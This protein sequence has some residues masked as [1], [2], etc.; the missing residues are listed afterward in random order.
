MK[1]WICDKEHDGMAD[2]KDG[3]VRHCVEC[4]AAI[5]EV[6]ADWE[7]KDR[8]EGEIDHL[9]PDE[10]VESYEEYAKYRYGEDEYN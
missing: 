10:W 4:E 6:L 2:D 8:K 7:K 9:V 1:C 3:K 5:Q